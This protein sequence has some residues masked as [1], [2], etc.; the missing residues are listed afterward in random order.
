MRVY[1]SID[2]EGVAG[3]ATFDQTVRG[4][5]G[6]PRAQR[7]MTAEANA[8]VQGA[9]DAGA[10]EV[11][12]EDSHG[13]MDNLLQDELDPRA[14]LVTGTPKAC[15][16][17][18]GLAEGDA[19][20]L[21]LGYHAASGEHGVLTHSFSG[22]F[23]QIRLD[24]RPVGETEVNGLYAA[25]LGVP[26]GLVTGDDVVCSVAEREFPGVQVVAVKQATGFHTARSL[27]PHA[28]AARIRAAAREAVSSSGGLSCRPVSGTMRVEIDFTSPLACDYAMTV[29]ESRRAGGHTLE[30]EVG[31]AHELLRLIS[32]CGY[33]S[34]YGAGE[35]AKV[36][37]RR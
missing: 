5:G 24:G 27:H 29:P 1:I 33:L 18:Q 17:V 15:A 20:A 19:V 35:L 11:V 26:V 4:G 31:S 14:L 21:F 36:G 32:A 3:I 6:Y 28:A 9:F 8:A 2:M 23:L 13:T 10:D 30:R 37:A 25:S 16:M 12:V 7:L 22:N 34:A